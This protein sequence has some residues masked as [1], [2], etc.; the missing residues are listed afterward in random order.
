MMVFHSIL[1]KLLRRD[2]MPFLGRLIDWWIFVIASLGSKHRSYRWN[3]RIG[4]SFCIIS[5]L[6]TIILLILTL[7]EVNSNIYNNTLKK[8]NIL[9]LYF[10]C[11]LLLYELREIFVLR[12]RLSSANKTLD[13]LLYC[14][15][16]LKFKKYLVKNHR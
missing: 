8:F 1:N 13:S 14:C 5:P 3:G 7:L 11:L 2:K 12:D 6:N 15:T 10:I 9:F 16:N 4:F